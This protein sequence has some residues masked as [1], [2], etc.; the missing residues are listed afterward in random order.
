MSELLTT[1][2][3]LLSGIKG[4]YDQMQDNN[5]QSSNLMKRLL[6]IEPTLREI[7]QSGIKPHHKRDLRDI[8]ETLLE[9]KSFLEMYSQKPPYGY[10]GTNTRVRLEAVF[11]FGLLIYFSLMLSYGLQIK[12]YC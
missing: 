8:N 6:M 3:D 5:D 10:N 2:F 11:G 4:M 7:E 12:K 1:V 9:A